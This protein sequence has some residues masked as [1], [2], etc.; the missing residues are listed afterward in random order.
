LQ[1]RGDYETW[2]QNGSKTMSDR[3]N[4]R[5]EKLLNE[6]QPEPIEDKLKEELNKIVSDADKRHS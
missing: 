1:D 3:V 6:H 2:Q 5:T 4:E